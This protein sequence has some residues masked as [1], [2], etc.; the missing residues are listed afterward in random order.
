MKINKQQ[1]GTRPT[2]VGAIGSA[3]DNTHVVVGSK[4]RREIEVCRCVMQQFLLTYL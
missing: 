3:P 1:I 4:S 2:A